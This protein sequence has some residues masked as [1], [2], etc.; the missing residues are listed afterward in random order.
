MGR[1]ERGRDP[2]DSLLS[3]FVQFRFELAE[4]ILSQTRLSSEP[5]ASLSAF[6]DLLLQAQSRFL[7]F[8]SKGSRFSS[9][10]QIFIDLSPKEREKRFQPVRPDRQPLETRSPFVRL[11]SRLGTSPA[12]RE[13]DEQHRFPTHA[14][15]EV[16]TLSPREGNQIVVNLPN[17]FLPFQA[18][19][20]DPDRKSV[21]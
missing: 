5:G 13:G 3:S 16:F 12:P 10:V 20:P 14:R 6:V 1:E 4:S 7:L 17:Y 19:S 18:R 9:L 11:A 8:R 15:S 21:V 2:T